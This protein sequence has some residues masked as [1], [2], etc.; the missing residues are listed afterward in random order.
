[1]PTKVEK[2]AITGQETTGHEWDGLKELNTPL[3]RWWLY[4]M[5]ASIAFAVVWW[6]LYP[7]WPWVHTYFPGILGYS[8]RKALDERMA[9]AAAARGAITK[10]LADASLAQI[11]GDQELSADRLRRRPG[12]VQRQLRAL[13]RPG[14]RGPGPLPE[15]GRRL[16]A[17]GRQPRCDPD[18]DQVRHPER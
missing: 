2:D 7:S 4:V 18:H 13:S 17:L 14:R 6:V 3:P 15:P 10:R 9:E 5:Y 8:Q 11:A 1:M 16:L 12:G